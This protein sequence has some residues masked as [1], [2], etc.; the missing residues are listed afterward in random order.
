MHSTQPE[1]AA[2]QISVLYSQVLFCEELANVQID[3]SVVSAQ[4]STKECMLKMTR[5]QV[6]FCFGSHLIYLVSVISC[7]TTHHLKGM[8]YH[9]FHLHAAQPMTLLSTS[10]QSN[11][12]IKD[13]N[14]PAPKYS[15]EAYCTEPPREDTPK[16]SFAQR[17]VACHYKL[18]CTSFRLIKDDMIVGK[19]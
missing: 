8:P 17:F 11:L 14:T 12:S 13:N 2:L 1:I 4:R 5:M 19:F 10:S 18:Y 7:Y 16:V 3:N 9:K 15:W 6:I